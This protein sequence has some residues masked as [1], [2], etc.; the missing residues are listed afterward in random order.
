MY[1][2]C[3]PGKADEVLRADRPHELDAAASG[4]LTVEE[5]ERGKG[6]MRGGIVLGLEDSGVADDAASA[7]ANWSTAT[8]SASTNCSL[9]ST[10]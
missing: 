8:C 2:G 5:I 6:Q 1:A 10:P 7:R 9:G 3:Q 4:D